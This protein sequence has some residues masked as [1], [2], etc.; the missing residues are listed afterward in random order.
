MRLYQF[1]ISH[2]CEKVRWAL[3][4]KR[5]ECE[6]ANLLPGLHVKKTMKMTGQSSVPV[7]QNGDDVISGSGDILDYLE[8][9]FPDVSLMPSNAAD[10][11]RVKEW[12][13][14]ADREIGV[15]VRRV[16]YHTLL[17]HPEVV[18]PFFTDNGPW[19]G[20]FLIGA[21][22]PKLRVRMRKYMKIDP[23]TAQQSLGSLD[24]AVKRVES[25]IP[26]GFLVGEQ[27][28][29]ADLTV[30]SLLAPL[31]MPKQYGLNPPKQLPEDLLVLRD[32]YTS[33]LSWVDKMYQAYRGGSH[34]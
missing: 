20:K 16:C 24:L 7:L 27:F 15:H 3:A 4:Y 33:V 8:K 1:P 31:I 21:V 12:E 5:I 26:N 25:A 29:R 19:Y 18:I 6:I 22:F 10:R 30:A 23:E 34:G 28:S 32:R 11:E 17:E 2:Y 9:S 13:E 14:F